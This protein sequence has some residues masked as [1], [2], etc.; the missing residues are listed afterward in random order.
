M[1]IFL[2]LLKSPED[3]PGFSY[4]PSLSLVI[5]ITLKNICLLQGLLISGKLVVS[6][7]LT[8]FKLSLLTLS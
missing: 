3:N 5:P 2:L 8:T 6:S 4:R 7:K 1:S